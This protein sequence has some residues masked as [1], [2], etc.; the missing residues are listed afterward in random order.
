MPVFETIKNCSSDVTGRCSEL[1]RPYSSRNCFNPSILFL[2]AETL[3]AFRAFGT[4]RTKPFAAYLFSTAG[5]ETAL[6]DLS[7]AMK[8]FGIANVS[9]PKL[10]ALGDEAWLTFNTGYSKTQ[11]NLYI[12]KVRPTVETPRECTV[13]GRQKVEKNWAFFEDRGSLKA[14]YSID[15]LVI[16]DV[17]EGPNQEYRFEKSFEAEPL[18]RQSLTIGT[19]LVKCEDGFKFIAHRKIQFLGK[20]LYFGV[21]G[22]LRIMDGSY[23]IDLSSKRLIH[24]HPSLLG[25]W[26]KHNPN[27]IS[28]T[29]FSGI[30]HTESEIILSY[31]INDLTYGF[32]SVSEQVLWR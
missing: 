17:K 12:L 25:S 21:P 20:R 10:F 30:A 7:E 29:Y 13:A 28:C 9:D 6:L 26:R 24:D 18:W 11:N 32:A 5:A 15:P 23:R 31:G 14:L 22:M 19:P 8:E 4:E 1:L 2:E 27:L 3:I 16:L